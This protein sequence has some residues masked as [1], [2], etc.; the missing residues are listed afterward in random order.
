[1]SNLFDNT[2]GPPSTSTPS[3]AWS[4][5]TCFT[6]SDGSAPITGL[7]WYRGS[8]TST[9]KPANLR[10]YGADTTVPLREFNGSDIVD[11]GAIGWQI[12]PFATAYTPSSGVHYVAQMTWPG[13]NAWYFYSRSSLANPASPFAWD[14][15]G[16]RRST[17][18]GSTYPGS[19]DDTLAWLVSPV[20]GTGTSGGGGLTTGD[21]DNALAKWLSESD[22]THLAGDGMPYDTWQKSIDTNTKVT[23]GLN[24]AGGIQA[25]SD[26][27]AHTLQMASDYLAGRTATYFTDLKNRLIGASGG[28]G[29]AFFGPAGTQV[30]AG[31]EALLARSTNAQVGFPASPWEKTA[32][33]DFD[34]CLAWAEPADLYTVSFATTPPTI[35]N[36]GQCGVPVRY[37]LAWWTPLNGEFA[38]ERHWIDFEKCHLVNPA[39]RMPGLLLQTYVSGT[40]HVEAWTLNV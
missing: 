1:V 29:S 26:S 28:G 30:S 20:W 18:F 37:R 21:L 34:G 2:V 19:Q 4:V 36:N 16:V 31:V 13:L 24:L 33:T 38:Q 3:N 9:A 12:T 6:V 27:L 11:S 17:E 14:S 23:G 22:A 8:T 32:E 15:A 5:G 10:L 25:L 40:G 39:G 7:A 35:P